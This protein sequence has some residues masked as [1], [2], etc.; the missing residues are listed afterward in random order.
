MS[1]NAS[2][3]R[4][5]QTGADFFMANVLGNDDIVLFSSQRSLEAIPTGALSRRSHIRSQHGRKLVALRAPCDPAEPVDAGLA[6][7]ARNRSEDPDRQ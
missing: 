6:G 2:V 5:S 4:N 1:A 7:R 3:E